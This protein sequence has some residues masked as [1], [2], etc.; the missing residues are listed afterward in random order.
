MSAP[1][2]SF[3][4]PVHNTAPWLER[5]LGSL[6]QNDFADLEVVAIDDGS[7]DGSLDILLRWAAKDSRLK[8]QQHASQQGLGRTRNTGLQAVSGEQSGSWIR[9]I[10]DMVYPI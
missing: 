3:I 9:T 7:T 4:V 10:G 1:R 2:L 5:C 8:V 6:L